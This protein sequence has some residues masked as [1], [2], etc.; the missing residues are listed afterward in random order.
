MTKLSLLSILLL[1]ACGS[2]RVAEVNVPANQ[3][4]S[5]SDSVYSKD[6]DGNV[7]RKGSWFSNNFE[8][9]NIIRTNT[10]TG[11][12]RDGRKITVVRE[13][14]EYP[15]GLVIQD[16]LG[17]FPLGDTFGAGRAM[18]GSEARGSLSS[19]PYCI[20]VLI[21]K[22]DP[23]T[24]ETNNVLTRH[25]MATAYCDSDGDGIFETRP[26]STFGI[27]SWVK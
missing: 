13:D 9:G 15:N 16:A 25:G 10:D 24:A 11:L 2:N 7:T 27:P 12:T 1:Y 8:R 23:A 3:T 21:H 6:A 4:S 18:Y 5:T 17:D 22:A 20:S 19:Q 14:F 26:G